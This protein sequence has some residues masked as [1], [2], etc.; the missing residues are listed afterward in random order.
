MSSTPADGV[1]LAPRQVGVAEPDRHRAPAQIR[2]RALAPNQLLITVGSLVAYG[3][4]LVSSSGNWRAMSPPT[5]SP[6]TTG[7]PGNRPGATPC[8]PATTQQPSHPKRSPTA[9]RWDPG[10]ATPAETTWG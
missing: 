1:P 7:D 5:G 9:H 8:P 2:S 10:L 6:A 3:V 4:N